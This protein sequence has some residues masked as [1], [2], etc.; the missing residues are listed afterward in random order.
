MRAFGKYVAAVLVVALVTHFALLQL[1]PGLIMDRVMDAIERR[2]LSPGAADESIGHESPALRYVTDPRQQNINDRAGWNVALPSGRPDHTSRGIV[3]PSPDLLYTVCLF[4]VSRGPVI[5]TAPV[6]D[7][8]VSL[9]GFA[10]NTDNFFAINDSQ[11]APDAEGRKRF[12]A[13][14]LGSVKGSASIPDDATVVAAP[15]DRGIVLFRSLVR[16]DAQLDELYRMQARQLC[17]PL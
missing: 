6:Q 9:S 11:V 13:V 8:Y 17:T 5:L 7:S 1:A 14:L 12:D 16:D 3:R 10:A 2:V 4:D 15:T